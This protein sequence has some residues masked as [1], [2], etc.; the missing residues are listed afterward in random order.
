MDRL[1]LPIYEKLIPKGV[2]KVVDGRLH[3]IHELVI[4]GILVLKY[5]PTN[6]SCVY[7]GFLLYC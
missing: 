7:E 5:M 3:K 4:D 1:S 6:D 2:R